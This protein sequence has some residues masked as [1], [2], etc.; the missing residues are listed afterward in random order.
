MRWRCRRGGQ[1][2][3]L[4]RSCSH[5]RSEPASH[6]AAPIAARAMSRGRPDARSLRAPLKTSGPLSERSASL[7]RLSIARSLWLRDRASGDETPGI[8]RTA[9]QPD[10]VWV[11]LGT[12]SRTFGWPPSGRDC[13]PALLAVGAAFN[14]H[15]GRRRR[16]P[17]WMQRSGTE[18]IY[19]LATDP[20]RLAGRYTRANVRFV[21]L[22]IEDRWKRV[23]K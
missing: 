4:R 16:A 22:L 11:G 1:A 20:R 23:F 13:A 15:A 19:R 9:A 3:L 10:Y 6:A 2:T 14:F 8:D 5:S 21:Q 18:W 7:Q 12:R 17:K